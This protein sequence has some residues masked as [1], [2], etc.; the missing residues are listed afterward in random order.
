MPELQ[1]TLSVVPPQLPPRSLSG[2]WKSSLPLTSEGEDLRQSC[3]WR[4]QLVFSEAFTF[5]T[6]DL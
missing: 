5:S 2:L 1:T 3:A 4:L 6:R